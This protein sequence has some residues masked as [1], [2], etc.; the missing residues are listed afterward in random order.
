MYC[1]LDV[2]LKSVKGNDETIIR[3]RN[4]FRLYYLFILS[5]VLDFLKNRIGNICT[6]Y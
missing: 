5:F 4:T 6:I 1:T 2:G 3:T